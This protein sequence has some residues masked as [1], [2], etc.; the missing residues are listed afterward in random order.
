MMPRSLLSLAAF[1]C[2]FTLAGGALSTA[3]ARGNATLSQDAA[4]NAKRCMAH[5]PRYERKMGIP[6]YLLEAISL[7]ESG[8]RLPG[9]RY[10]APWPWT[11][12]TG[13]RGYYFDT[14]QEAVD[15]V[16]SVLEK[17]N[18]Y[19]DVGCMQVNIRYHHQA[20]RT[21]E[22]ALDPEHNVAYGA[23][24][25]RQNYERTG[26]WKTAAMHYHSQTPGRG[27]P[28]LQGVLRVWKNLVAYDGTRQGLEEWV[29]PSVT[30][31]AAHPWQLGVPGYMQPQFLQVASVQAAMPNQ[32]GAG[33]IIASPIAEE[34]SKPTKWQRVMQHQSADIMVND[35]GETVLAPSSATSTP[36][37]GEAAAS[38][39]ASDTPATAATTVSAPTASA[40]PA[41][42]S[43]T[44]S[45]SPEVLARIESQTQ[46]IQ[47]TPQQIQAAQQGKIII[48]PSQVN[49]GT[50]VNPVPQV[51]P[52][53]PA[54]L[55][56]PANATPQAV[57]R[58]DP[59]DLRGS[60]VSQRE[61][62]R[63]SLNG[64]RMIFPR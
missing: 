42:A 5:I 33:Q 47:L 2:A 50:L 25:L 28:Y 29:E 55:S 44:S 27:T 48:D 1:V 57:N 13:G 43:Q 39:S 45:L 21:V 58:Y 60:A 12:N 26:S 20:F 22:E 49:G 15:F 11:V 7:S 64:V 52:A 38:P 10:A 6:L 8:R 54:A 62:N 23:S 59:Q 31:A 9:L 14:K 3:Q 37:A 61:E 34:P 4:A 51:T 40:P 16:Y 63:T 53:T 18:P 36:A 56:N 35:A 41:N 30:T 32:L 17:G 46:H 19:I 24:F